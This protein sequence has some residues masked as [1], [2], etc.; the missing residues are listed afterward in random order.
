MPPCLY[1]LHGDR[2]TAQAKMPSTRFGTTRQAPCEIIITER[3]FRANTSLTSPG[4]GHSESSPP[5]TSPARSAPAALRTRSYIE[6]MT[7]VPRR[8][9]LKGILHWTF[10][11]AIESIARFCLHWDGNTSNFRYRD[12]RHLLRLP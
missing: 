12:V 8:F 4:H 11:K 2:V 3:T 10:R 9:D 5:P 1:C 6:T 7:K